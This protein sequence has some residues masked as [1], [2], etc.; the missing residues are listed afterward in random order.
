MYDDFFFL[1]ENKNRIKRIMYSLQ[2]KHVV[3]KII[4]KRD[5]HEVGTIT[6]SVYK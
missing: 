1:T 2:I 6:I 4:L 5:K 3:K